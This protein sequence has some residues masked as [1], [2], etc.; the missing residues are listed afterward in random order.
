MDVSKS[1]LRRDLNYP[2]LMPRRAWPA[3][4]VMAR[5]PPFEHHLRRGA[6]TEKLG[7]DEDAPNA[8]SHIL[9]AFLVNMRM[10]ICV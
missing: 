7:W 10:R 1:W 9:P 5:S 3:A 6:S 2:G 4:L 8:P